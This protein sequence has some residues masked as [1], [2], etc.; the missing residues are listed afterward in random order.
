M[1]RPISFGRCPPVVKEA[2]SKADRARQPRC[3]RS[4]AIGCLF[5]EPLSALNR[6]FHSGPPK[7][8]E[9][10]RSL[11]ANRWG[12]DAISTPRH[13]NVGQLRS[14]GGQE[15][16]GSCFAAT[17]Q[18]RVPYISLRSSSVTWLPLAIN[19]TLAIPMNKPCSTI[20]GISLSLRASEG[21]S[22]IWPKLQSR[23]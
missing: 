5:L 9:Y 21:G 10:F 15:G 20:P 11:D 4:R 2:E 13:T 3:L 17:V 8:R 19:T 22:E 7:L 18:L 1:W 12:S 14:L 16:A 6:S 23:I